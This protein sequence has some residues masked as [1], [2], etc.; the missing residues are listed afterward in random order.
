MERWQRRA[1][2][3]LSRFAGPSAYHP[4]ELQKLEGVVATVQ[5]GSDLVDDER[6][7]YFDGDSL[8]AAGA[9]AFANINLL[10]ANGD[11]EILEAW[12]L[13]P[14]GV[15]NLG[16]LVGVSLPFPLPRVP[17]ALGPGTSNAYITALAGGIAP[18]VPTRI[19]SAPQSTVLEVP[20]R[21]VLEKGRS[22]RLI[23]TTDNVAMAG[24]FTWRNLLGAED[25]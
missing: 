4:V 13:A 1:E 6:T 22:L 15:L 18:A 20:V 5:L 9:G 10:A 12:A 25:R 14:G 11:I 23:S 16:L 8:A 21:G 7:V 19:L 17:L 3:F 24:G 2:R